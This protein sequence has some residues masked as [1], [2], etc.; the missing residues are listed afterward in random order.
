MNTFQIIHIENRT[1]CIVYRILIFSCSNFEYCIASDGV[2]RLG[3]RQ[4]CSPQ[5]Q[6]E[7]FLFYL[8][9]GLCA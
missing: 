9:M 8:R 5:Q 2:L 3:N 6:M 7:G 1:I 4:T